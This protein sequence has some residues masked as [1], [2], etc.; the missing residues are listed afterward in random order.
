MS[1]FKQCDR[2]PERG[3]SGGAGLEPV[4]RRPAPELLEAYL[5]F[6]RETWDHVHDHYI[7]HDPAGFGAWRHTLFSDLRRA[8]QGIAL[9]PGIVPSVTYWI[10]LGERCI[11]VG[12]LRPHLNHALTVYGGHIGIAI[13]PAARCRG[14]AHR[15]FL[16]LFG[17]AEKFG[18]EELLL[19]CFEENSASAR[20]LAGLPGAVMEKDEVLLGGR[21][22]RIRRYRYAIPQKVAVG[23]V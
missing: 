23:P 15:A 4:L 22:R 2:G 14:Y 21:M 16:L 3:R 10:F 17:E 6:C 11:G 7:L 9:P 20:L 5:D 1:L 19:T 8:E 13:R 18:I 12:N